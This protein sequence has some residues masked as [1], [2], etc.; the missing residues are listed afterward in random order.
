[1]TFISVN[2]RRIYN[3]PVARELMSCLTIKPTN[4]S[5]Y[6]HLISEEGNKLSEG[7]FYTPELG[8]DRDVYNMPFLLNEDLSPW[9]EANAYLFHL[10]ENQSSNNRPTDKLH[11]IASC[12]LQYKVFTEL[13]E[14]DYLDFSGKR[15]SHR[16]TARYYSYLKSVVGYKPRVTNMH[17]QVVYDFL[18][19]LADNSLAHNIDKNRIDN[20]KTVSVWYKTSKGHYAETKFKK[21]QLSDKTGPSSTPPLQMVRDEGEDLRPLSLEQFKDLRIAL[22]RNKWNTAERLIIES[23]FKTGARKQSILTIRI[24]DIKSWYHSELGNTGTIEVQAG[25]GTNINTKN[26]KKLTLYFPRSLVVSL[27]IYYQSDTAKKRREKFKEN[28]KNN[29]PDLK[30][31]NDEQIYLFLSDQG[32]CYYMANNDPRYKYLKSVP[33]GQISNNLQNKIQKLT[34]DNFPSNFVFHWLR[35]TFGYLL[36]VS[37]K[38]KIGN[39]ISNDMLGENEVTDSDIITIIQK[40]MGHACRTTTENYLKLF[41][42]IEVRLEVQEIFEEEFINA[43]IDSLIIGNE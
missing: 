28:F 10:I 25:P 31:M 7:F 21:R 18:V 12:I 6:E 15:L 8:N 27:Y 13:E 1:M 33:K 24:G 26:G 37:I 16:P 9:S 4:H 19:Y 36:F 22:E 35:A 42:N 29:Y 20:V 40:R 14:I 23:A 30:I 38:K 5:L 34:P 32:N 39:L 17:T 41:R 2:E 3:I 43:E 11:R